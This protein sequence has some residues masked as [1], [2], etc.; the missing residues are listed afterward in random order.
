MSPAALLLA[1]LA[2]ASPG[3]ADQHV[4]AGA[5]AFRA[6]HYAEALVEFRVAGRLDGSGEAGWYAASC[7]VRLGRPE[8]AVEAFDE[9]ARR[10]PDIRDDLFSYYN[11][12]AC[13]DARLYLCADGLLAKLG[14]RSGPRIREEASRL[15]ARVAAVLAGEPS[16]ATVDW[17]LARAQE[18]APRR[19]LLA[20]A[21][22]R[23]AAGLAAHRRD[24][25]RRTEAETSLKR[26]GAAP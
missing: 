16:K 9:S 7:L 24:G 14:E 6:A 3:P 4:L 26:A 21:Y 20:A 5:R 25:Y 23:E 15:R 11:A 12:V 2:A 1:A 18:S 10:A 22:L 13:H 19:H 8:D 17:Y